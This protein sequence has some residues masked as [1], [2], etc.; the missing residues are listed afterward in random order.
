MR[1]VVKLGVQP[2]FDDRAYSKV[3][4]MGNVVE[5]LTMRK[6]PLGP[7]VQIISKDEYIDLRTGELCTRQHGETRADALD[8]IRQTLAN[9]RALVNTNVVDASCCRW[10]TLTYRDNMTD[11]ERLYRDFQVFWQRFQRFCAS[12][13]YSKPEYI[14]VVEP[15]GRGAWHIHAFFIWPSPAPFIDNNSV[16]APMWGHGFTKIKAL[17][18]VDNVGA[19]FSAYLADIPLDEVLTLPADDRRLVAPAGSVTVVTKSFEDSRETIKDKKFVKGGRLAL[20][21]AGMN[22]VRTS[23]GIKKPVVEKMPHAKAKEKVSA[24]TLTFSRAYAI[25]LDGTVQNILDK[26]YYNRLRKKKQE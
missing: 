8:G 15:Q 16:L 23:R 9:I 6:R 10:V 20:Y 4:T 19:Y 18:D 25:V 14:N 3:T 11:R 21:P 12:N 5:V 13:G 22:I 7:P 2:A 24:A 1:E 26:S 17:H